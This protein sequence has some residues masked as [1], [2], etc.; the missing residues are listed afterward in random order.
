MVVTTDTILVALKAGV[1]TLTTLTDDKFFKSKQPDKR[2]RYPSVELIE[3]RPQGSTITQ[4]GIDLTRQF[5]VKIFLRFI[6]GQAGGQSNEVSDLETLEIEILGVLESTVLAEHKLITETKEFTRTFN[7]DSLPP[8]IV[9]I[10]RL[11]LRE[12]TPISETP[13]GILIFDTSASTGDDKPGADYTY[14]QAFNTDIFEEFPDIEEY[15]TQDSNPK[16]YTGGFR[17]N[18]I[19]HIKVKTA[20]FGTT[21]DK[22]NQI[23]KP[24]AN[25]E[26]PTV[27]F[28]YTNKDGTS[29]TSSTINKTVTLKVS[30]ITE[31]YRTNQ[32]TVFRLLG[33]LTKPSTTAIT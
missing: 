17:G 18:I 33:R 16:Q 29:P 3:V 10:L 28:L 26:K 21:T 2:R 7:N 1:Y 9:S 25:G 23:G 11:T 24:Q 31:L 12:I 14:T 20:D 5:D 32:N 13:D 22:L 19:T 4:E 30:N 15:T 8:Y 27:V 6:G